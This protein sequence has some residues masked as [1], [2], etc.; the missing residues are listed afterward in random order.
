MEKPEF[1]TIEVPLCGTIHYAC[2]G[3]NCVFTGGNEKFS[4]TN[5][6]VVIA[7]EIL[8]VE[9]GEVKKIFDFQT[10]AGSPLV[11]SGKFDFRQII[12]AKKINQCKSRNCWKI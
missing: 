9:A 5:F 3:N 6:A 10:H 2:F 7:A 8:A 12:F 11:K 4:S 1:K